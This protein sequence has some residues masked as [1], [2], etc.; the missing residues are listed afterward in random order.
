M[1]ENIDKEKNENVTR[2]FKSGE[3]TDCIFIFEEEKIAA[4]KLVLTCSSPVFKSMFYGALAASEIHINDIKAGDFKQML[5]Y[6]YT[7]SIT[8]TSIMNAWSLF[9]ISQKYFLNGL[10][11]ICEDYVA[12]NLTLSTLV[13]SYE[14]AQ[15]YNVTHLVNKCWQDILLGA[16]EILQVDYHMQAST[17]CLL[18]DENEVNADEKDLIE[19]ALKWSDEECIIQGLDITKE[20]KLK[21]LVDSGIFSRLRFACLG[22]DSCN[23]L[24]QLLTSNLEAVPQLNQSTKL[25]QRMSSNVKFRFRETYKIE[26]NIRLTEGN[27]FHCVVT[28]ANKLVAYGIAISPPHQDGFETATADVL[29]KI[30]D[31]K[32][33]LLC[34]ATDFITL[35]SGYENPHL[36]HFKSGVIFEESA[37]YKIS[38]KYFSTSNLCKPNELLC[39]YLSNFI[40][41]H[42]NSMSL[43]FE[44]QLCG[45][46][47]RGIS[48]YAY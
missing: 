31:K 38:V 29:I 43:H 47:I 4:H 36:I 1:S 26:R 22:R 6:I 32:G 33:N 20:N 42:A 28:T 19:G 40:N 25:R 46:V 35:T 30:S 17:F 23:Y 16:R 3:W 13:L 18:L 12:F 14:Y 11:E 48:F 5:E 7:D 10:K 44:D 41:T 8:I 37:P 34:E 39:Y 27:E 45:G 15:L 21:I 24:Y 9:Y 2:L